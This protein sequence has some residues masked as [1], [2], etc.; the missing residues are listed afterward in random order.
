M[1][2]WKVNRI[3]YDVY[4]VLAKFPPYLWVHCFTGGYPAPKTRRAAHGGSGEQGGAHVPKPQGLK[5]P[6]QPP[7]P[8]NT[9]EAPEG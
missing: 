8:C 7:W 5:C 6:G 2:F 3:I 4:I 9:Q 1:Y